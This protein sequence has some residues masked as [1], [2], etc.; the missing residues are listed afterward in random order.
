[1]RIDWSDLRAELAIWRA[2]ARD[3]P[4]WWRDDDAVE[5]TGALTQLIELAE[6]IEVPLHLAVIPSDAK[7]SLAEVAGAR[8]L[9][10][11]MVHGWA[12]HTHAPEGEKKAEFGNPRAEAAAE[13]GL[14]LTRLKVLFPNDI[15]GFFV[16]PWNRIDARLIASLP[17]A[18]YAGLSTFTPRQAAYPVPGLVQINTHLDPIFWRG[19]GGLVP[20]EQLISGLVKTL[21]DRRAGVTDAAEPLGL[22]THH[23]VHDAAIWDFTRGVLEELLGGGARAVSLRNVV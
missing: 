16:P 1:M 7:T 10:V 11:P 4:I 15:I 21:Q 6:T 13:M 23:L 5:A 8:P 3:L 9:V 22:L 2:E 18:G 17:S 12:H 19:G 20:P 14:G